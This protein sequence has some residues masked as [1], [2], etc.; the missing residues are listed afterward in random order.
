MIMNRY[1]NLF[2]INLSMLLLLWII[3]VISI[4]N[5]LLLSNPDHNSESYKY[6]NSF[7]YGQSNT[8]TNKLPNL[9]SDHNSNEIDK[10]FSN[11]YLEK[12]ATFDDNRL[13]RLYDSVQ[14]SIVK[15]FATPVTSNEKPSFGSGF[16]YDFEGHIVTN[17]HVVAG[18][19]YNDNFD[20]AFTDG[21]NSKAN[22]IGVD[23]QSDIAVLQLQYSGD[24]NQKINIDPLIISNFSSV[25]VGQKVVAIGNPFGLSGSITQGIISGL[26]RIITT[27]P[28]QIDSEE[29]DFNSPAF[30]IPNIIQTDAAINP[31][32]SGGPLLNMNGEVVGINTA[33]YSKTGQF[34][35]VGFAIPSYLIKRVVPS[36][37]LEGKYFHPKLGI[38]GI[39]INNDIA[40]MM[41]LRN[42]DG[43][44]VT[45]VIKGSPA[46]E[47]GIQSG[48]NLINYD[49]EQIA[50]G[51]DVIVSADGIPIRNLDDLLSYLEMEKSPG[52]IIQLSIIRNGQLEHITTR[53][54]FLLT[55]GNSNNQNFPKSSEGNG[56]FNVPIL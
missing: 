35:G 16:I 10:N 2:F 6:Y 11:F 47:A 18:A 46:D 41:N 50:I 15:V 1:S 37:I 48:Y 38:Y 52:Q 9:V 28:L 24:K 26:G 56:Y 36:L 14:H 22:L 32:N 34:S 53:I 4:G 30:S 19:G 39:D 12:L 17:Y 3:G 23:P 42:A 7:V 31:G 33:I 20:I 49:G 43:F 44:L 40:E 8:Q 27:H 13:V 29:F 21:T 54:G 51:G 55:Y 45:K 5:M 25:K